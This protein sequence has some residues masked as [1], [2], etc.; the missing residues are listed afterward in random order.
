M[1]DNR[2]DMKEVYVEKNKRGCLGWVFLLLFLGFNV[3]MLVSLVSY[4]VSIGD[5]MSE[6]PSEAFQLGAAIGATLGTGFLLFIWGCGSVILGVIVFLTR[7]KKI[8]ERR[9]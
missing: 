8:I 5:I 3:F 1:F 7:G 9:S 6:D 2:P 4:W